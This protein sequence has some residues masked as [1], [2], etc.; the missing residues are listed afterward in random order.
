MGRDHKQQQ[1]QQPAGKAPPADDLAARLVPT[2]AIAAHLAAA[3]VAYAAVAAA[4]AAAPP[5]PPYMLPL[6]LYSVGTSAAVTMGGAHELVHSRHPV[7]L[8]AAATFLTAYWW[9]PYYRAHHQHHLH[10]CTPV[11]YTCAPKGL[12]VYS[13]FGQYFAG[14]YAEAWE[15]SIQECDRAGQPHFSATNSTLVALGAQALL[16]A[17]LA[18]ALGPAAAAF[19]LGVTVVMLTYMAIFDYVLHY[20]LVRPPLAA[21]SNPPPAAAA[22]VTSATSSSSGG[23]GGGGRRRYT[24]ITPYTSWNSLYPLENGMLF[25]VLLHSD[26]H[27]AASKSYGWLRAPSASS[28]PAPLFPSPINLLGLSVFIPPLWRAIMDERADEANARHLEYL[29]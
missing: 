23:G 28:S 27:L 4:A 26:H 11:D 10:V 5:Q 18:A 6:L 24:P 13:Y 19:H 25:S 3:A 12:N 20:G 8:A 21:T 14:S 1:Q 22:A 16:T 2:L 7:H 29:S 9:Y 17:A 15:L